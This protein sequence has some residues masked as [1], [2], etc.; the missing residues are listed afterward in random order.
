MLIAIIWHNT[1]GKDMYI[2]KYIYITYIHTYIYIYIYIQY[3][4]ILYIQ[5]IHI[6]YIHIYI[7]IY[8]PIPPTY[9]DKI[10]FFLLGHGVFWSTRPGGNH[11]RGWLWEGSGKSPNL[12]DVPIT[13]S[14]SHM[15]IIIYNIHI[16]K[17]YNMSY[18]YLSTYLSTYPIHVPWHISWHIS[19]HI[20]WHI[21][22]VC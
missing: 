1:K 22:K 6:L 19:V 21:P 3:I 7:H 8:I 14:I 18:T 5:Y 10:T 17:S 15:P 11:Q 12:D 4:H 13:T 9:G 20:P 2:Y 16:Y